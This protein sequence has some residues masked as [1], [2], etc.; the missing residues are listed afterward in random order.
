M[1]LDNLNMGF[2]NILKFLDL[3]LEQQK[4]EIINAIDA[5]DL[6]KIDC[7]NNNISSVCLW[8][9]SLENIREEIFQSPLINSVLPVSEDKSVSADSADSD[10]D[11]KIPDLIPD[12]KSNKNLKTESNRIFD[13]CEEMI[14]LKPYDMAIIN[15]V[16]NFSSMFT[17]KKSQYMNKPLKLSNGLWVETYVTK[18]EAEIIIEDILNYCGQ[19][20]V[21]S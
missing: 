2:S 12:L 10:L 5:R 3:I 18:E 8:K 9:K 20:K 14:L 16:K 13:V 19:T 21:L 7:V 17:D 15:T 6:D 1:N 4:T 11:K